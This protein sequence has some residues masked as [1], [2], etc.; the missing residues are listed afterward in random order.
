L[1]LEDLESNDGLEVL[2]EGAVGE[3]GEE[4]GG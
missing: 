1:K 3:V 2:R 4:E